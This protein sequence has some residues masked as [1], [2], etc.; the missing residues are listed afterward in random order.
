MR[1]KVSSDRLPSYIKVTR[2][3]LEIFKMAG[4]FPDRLRTLSCELLPPVYSELHGLISMK[5]VTVSLAL[6]TSYLALVYT[7]TLY[8][9]DRDFYILGLTY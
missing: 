9:V 2:P 5:M 6:R 3:V 1:S 8:P 7:G 4:Y